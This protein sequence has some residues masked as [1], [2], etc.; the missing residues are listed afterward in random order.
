MNLILRTLA[1][2]LPVVLAF[3]PPAQAAARERLPNIIYIMVDDMGYAD[4]GPYGQKVIRT[5]RLDRMA[6][7]GLRFTDV[8]TGASVCAP[9]RSV[10][11]TGQHLG[12]TRVRGNAGMAGGIPDHNGARRVPLEPHDITVAEVLKS[13]GYVTGMTGKWGLGEPGSTGEPNWKGFDEWFGYLN[14]NHAHTHY[15]DYLWRNQQKLTIEPNVNKQRGQHTHPLFTDFALDFIR[16]QSQRPF[17]LYVPYTLPHQEMAV[18]SLGA[19]ANE[20]WTEEEKVFAAMITLID[21]DVGRMLD[22]L[23]ELRI[24]DNTIVFFCSDNGGWR[25]YEGRFDSN[26]PFRGAKGDLWEGGLRTSM[27][28]RWP[29]RVP[30]GASSDLPWYFADVMPTLAELAGAAVPPN[31]DG[32]SVLPAI[33][34][35]RQSL[36]RMLYWEQYGGGAL[37]QAARWGR[38][39]GIRHE[40][41][42]VTF[43]LYDL[44]ADIGET[45]DVAAGNPDV[46]RRMEAFLASAYTPSPNWF[47]QPQGQGPGAPK[48]KKKR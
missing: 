46:V 19:Y 48:T 25:R 6:A 24:E 35:Q 29:G 40:A 11:M 4:I 43:E 8:Y 26:K 17:F 10:L 16:R 31:I 2:L 42:A 9:S 41:A 3:P 34:G 22:L 33:L 23:R 37:Q 45:R 27:I 5:P 15:P 36:D 14:Q 20:S 12:H 1:L 44:A 21:Q 7:E 38:W 13:R 18:P 47:R 39:K 32:V 28:V 30:S